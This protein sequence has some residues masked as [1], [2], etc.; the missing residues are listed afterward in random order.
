MPA[1]MLLCQRAHS[2][3]CL[4]DQKFW[5]INTP[6]EQTSTNDR[7]DLAWKYPVSLPMGGAIHGWVCFK[8]VPRASLVGLCSISFQPWPACHTPV[9]APSPFCL[10][11]L[12]ALFPSGCLSPPKSVLDFLFQGLFLGEPQLRECLTMVKV[13]GISFLLFP[14]H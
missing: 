13:S 10:L 3:I 8:L 7:W 14:K 1:P 5:G 9:Q 11:P 12:A 6:W 4:A 2:A